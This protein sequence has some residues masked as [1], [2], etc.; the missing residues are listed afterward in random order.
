M[1]KQNV[2]EE[3]EYRKLV[4]VVKIDNVNDARPLCRTL[5]EGGLP[6][7]EITFRTDAAE[8]SIRIA[9][10]CYP[11]MLVGAG[12]VTSVEQAERA[13]SAGA[14]FLV[15]PGFSEKVAD[16]AVSKDI[17]LLP[18]T[19]TPTEIMKAMDYGFSVVKFFP[20][21]QYGG[22][23]TI[24]TLSAPF[25]SMKFMPTGGINSVN[26]KEYLAFRQIIACGG[27]WM[28]KPDLFTNGDFTE[29]LSLT[30][31]AVKIVGESNE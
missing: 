19:C 6:C 2:L 10:K 5:I 27:S 21:Q 11:E 7:A 22:L 24:K 3:I 1:T 28:V 31:E 25:P 13:V 8:E 12:T 20:A 4:P 18:G 9:T 29:V 23:T 14:K 26:I 17:L 15:S 30:K 16:F